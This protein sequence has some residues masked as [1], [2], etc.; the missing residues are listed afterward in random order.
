MI[1]AWLVIPS[2]RFTIRK[3]FDVRAAAFVGFFLFLLEILTF[4]LY[5]GR[6]LVFL[7]FSNSSSSF[8]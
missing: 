3:T 6:Y 2:Q 1:E 4:G 8:L 7:I 5:S